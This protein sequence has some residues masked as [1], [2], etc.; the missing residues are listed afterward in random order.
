[1]STAVIY[2]NLDIVDFSMQYLGFR[3][4]NQ[5]MRIEPGSKEW[6]L[7]KAVLKNVR[8]ITVVPQTDRQKPPRPIK[9]LVPQAGLYE[10]KIGNEPWTVQ[11]CFSL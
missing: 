2:R 1:M 9:D 5:L 11:V 10:F 4:V 6:K 8:V 3:D 7:L